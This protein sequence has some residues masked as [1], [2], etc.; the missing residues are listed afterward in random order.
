MIRFACICQKELS[1]TDDRAGTSIQCPFCGKLIDVPLLSEL[2]SLQA[3]GT[4]KVDPEVQRL[5]AN[6]LADLHRSFAPTRVD[7][8]GRDIDLRPTQAD[9]AN[10][11]DENDEIF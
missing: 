8:Y 6:R 4:Y 11:G 10:I 5:E 3:D 9:F 7:E 2:K 1:V